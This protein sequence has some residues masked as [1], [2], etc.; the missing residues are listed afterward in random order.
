[1]EVL[2]EGGEIRVAELSQKLN[3]SVV[4]IRKDLDELEKEGLL[5][6]VHGGAIKNYRAQ[7]SLIFMDR[8]NI[9]KEEKKRIAAATANLIKEGDSVI[10]NVGSTSYYVAKEFKNKK[11]I[12][13]ITNGLMIFNE[14]AYYKNLTALFL[15]GL[16]NPEMQITYGEDTIEQ[17]SK[18]KA[19]KLIIGMDGIDI[20]AG[21]T[22][23]NHVEDT[24][25][26]VMIERSKEKILIV[27]DSKLGKITFAHIAPLTDFD[28]IVTNYAPQHE[29]YYES[30]R[31]LGLNVIT[32]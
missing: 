4:T 3:T 21:A 16:F 13:V 14:L 18:Y 30:L 28:A 22:T 26:R 8:K 32:V 7:Q 25:M 27:D 31:A 15:G 6:R 1:M 11:N 9:K 19:D 5:E 24:I 23:Y 29:Q 10:L 12:I 20:N 17:L 2:I